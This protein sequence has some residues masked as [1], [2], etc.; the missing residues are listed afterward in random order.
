MSPSPTCTSPV[1]WHPSPSD[2]PHAAERKTEVQSG[3]VPVPGP[4]VH[5]GKVGF[6]PKRGPKAR[7]PPA[8]GWPP[9]LHDEQKPERVQVESGRG[10]ASPGEPGTWPGA[11]LDVAQGGLCPKRYRQADVSTPQG[12]SR[13]R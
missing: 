1:G 4:T 2:C 3:K 8:G 10:F 13:P 6:K 12:F 7:S 5:S 11:G 9:L